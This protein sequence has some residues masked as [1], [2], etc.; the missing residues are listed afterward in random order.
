MRSTMILFLALFLFAGACLAQTAP[1]IVWQRSLGG[2]GNDEAF[3]IQ[4]TTDGGFIVAGESPSNDGDVSGN[5][6]ERDYWVVK[7]NSSG[8]IVWQKWLGGSDYDEAHSIQQ[9]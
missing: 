7:L 8:D 6:G 4:Q 1:S 9:T 3:S 5:H 2:S